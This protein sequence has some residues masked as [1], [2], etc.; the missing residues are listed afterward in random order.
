MSSSKNSWIVILPVALVAA[1]Y[2]IWIYLPGR[3]AIAELRDQI[4]S[5][6]DFVMETEKAVRAV[7]CRQAGAEKDFRLRGRL[8]PPQGPG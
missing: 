1:A 4:R 8:P 7:A 5:K 3:K 6:Q 2:V